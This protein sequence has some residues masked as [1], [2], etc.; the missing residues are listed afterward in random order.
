MRRV[1]LAGALVL[2]APLAASQPA[3]DAHLN[4]TPRTAE[5]AGRV[6][7]VTA[8]ATS[9]AAPEPFETNPGGA[10][11]NRR[12]PDANA[13]SFSSANLDFAKEL[14]FK[15]GNGIFRKLWVSAPSSTQASDGLGPIFNSRA[16]QNCHLKDARGHPPAPGEPATQMFL[17]L[18]VPSDHDAL[19]GE[20]ADWI[21]AAP[22]PVYGGQ[23]QTFSIAGIPA[24]GRFTIDYA[25]EEVALA[26][27]ETARL[28]RPSYGVADLAY[29][30]MAED[31][32]MSPRVA[33]QMIG[34]GL[35]EAIPAADILAHAD[36]DDAD[37][38]GISGRPNIVWS[39]EFGQPML[40]R[41]GYKAG[42]PT[43][44]EQTAAAFAG[45]IGIS[46][47]L[48]PDGWG[49]CTAAQAACR[50][51]P[52]GG[53]PEAED[54]ALDLVTFYS[55]NLA[56]PARRDPGDPEVLR[57]KELFYAT[58]CAA[59]H[60]PKFVTHRLTDRPEQSFQ[61]IWPYSDFLLHD[62][63]EGLAD[64][65]PEG[66]AE[67]REWRTAPLWGIGLTGTVTGQESFLHDGRARSL[68]EA[69]LWHGGEAQAAR[70]RVV[71]MTPEER[72]AL[73]RFLGSL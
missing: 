24:E 42:M 31:V 55:R 23:F 33:P 56:V 72:A 48:H 39:A 41:F 8:P 13:F 1:L 65:R 66:R 59:C 47:R 2:A 15:V 61:L 21:G 4:V 27:G 35:V 6:V 7:S 32:M 44:R 3:G 36:P 30:P 37:G 43:I 34:L 45:D 68:L 26:G 54:A 18:S 14:D 25:E 5:E 11:T 49:D 52:H 51:A 19:A 60:A 53:D 58:G 71:E 62:M 57:G 70:D 64:N 40:G 38:D 16:C 17:R 69:V 9:F 28:R 46:T 20:I 12:R 63:G 29:G 10:A 67:G 73:L 22:E 50:A